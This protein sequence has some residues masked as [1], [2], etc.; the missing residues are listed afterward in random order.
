MHDGSAGRLP[1]MRVC[2]SFSN[3][4]AGRQVADDAGASHVGKTQDGQENPAI[5]LLYEKGFEGLF[6]RYQRS[7]FYKGSF[8][9]LTAVSFLSINHLMN[10]SDSFIMMLPIMALSNT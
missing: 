7:W 5:S 10:Q 6:L 1:A 4:G 3:V 2:T 9:C 8:V